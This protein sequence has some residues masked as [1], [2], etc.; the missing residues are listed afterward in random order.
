MQIYRIYFI[1]SKYSIQ[2]FLHNMKIINRI[3]QYLEYKRIAPTRAEKEIGLSNGYLG[4]QM[5]KQGDIGEGQLCK[6][7]EYYR[8]IN[9]LWLLTGEGEMLK[10]EI[11]S[12]SNIVNEPSV[13][14]TRLKMSENWV[15]EK[16][17]ILMNDI[18][19]NS[20]S[21]A[22]M[23]DIAEKNS[24]ILEKMI[25]MVH[26]KCINNEDEISD[27]KQPEKDIIN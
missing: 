20:Q 15:K 13:E 5:K 26:E 8:D 2:Y 11:T 3:Y 19:Q 6:F 27:N 4:V 9:P 18:R 12:N 17:D 7:I 14:Y 23:V 24:G 10:S 22:K 1:Y 25:G 21:I 16:I